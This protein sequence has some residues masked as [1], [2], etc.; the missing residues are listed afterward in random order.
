MS[1]NQVPASADT[2][3]S[4]PTTGTHQRPPRKG[5]GGGVKREYVKE[6]IDANTRIAVR[7]QK[8]ERYRPY[9]SMTVGKFVEHENGESFVPYIPVHV[10]THLAKVEKVSDHSKLVAEMIREATDWI[11]EACQ[12]REDEIIAEKQE[13][14]NRQMNREKGPGSKPGLKT[15]S[16]IDRAIKNFG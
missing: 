10:D 15:L 4:T 6:I 3:P 2:Q 8:T 5:E 14:E 12:K 7:I 13:R 9:Y 16:K 1:D 11:R